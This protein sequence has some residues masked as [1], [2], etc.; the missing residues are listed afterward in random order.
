LRHD[1][2]AVVRGQFAE[3]PCGMR[4]VGFEEDMAADARRPVAFGGRWLRLDT[5]AAPCA[6]PL[7]ATTPAEVQLLAFDTPI[8]LFATAL[9]TDTAR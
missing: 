4:V 8:T 3:Q 9:A 5:W 2:E 1:R 7:H 6:D